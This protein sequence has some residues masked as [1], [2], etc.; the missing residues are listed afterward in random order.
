MAIL[1]KFLQKVP[2][3]MV[4]SGLFLFTKW[5]NFSTKK[6]KIKIKKSLD[7]ITWAMVGALIY[8]LCHSLPID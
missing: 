4:C 6:K 3:S 2:L 7:G 5:Q 8:R 1:V